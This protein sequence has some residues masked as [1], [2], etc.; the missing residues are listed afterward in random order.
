[1]SVF[2]F[3]LGSPQSFALW[4][5]RDAAGAETEKRKRLR[6]AEAAITR[7]RGDWT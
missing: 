6:L 3:N 5:E 4:G 1:M 2:V 7:G